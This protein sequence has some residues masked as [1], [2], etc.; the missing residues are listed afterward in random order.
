MRYA[1]NANKCFLEMLFLVINL[2]QMLNI[3][4]DINL[5]DFL[6]ISE[7]ISFVFFVVN[8]LDYFPLTYMNMLGLYEAD[9]VSLT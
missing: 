9:M 8:M 7:W 3:L 6:P 2:F 4:C 1:T 5:A